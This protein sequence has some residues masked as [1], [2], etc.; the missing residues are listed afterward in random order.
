MK[1][2]VL[3][4]NFTIMNHSFRTKQ[5]HTLKIRSLIEVFVCYWLIIELN[6][7]AIFLI[8][9][10]FSCAC[11]TTFILAFTPKMT[12][13]ILQHYSLY[14]KLMYFSI[15]DRPFVTCWQFIPYHSHKV[16]TSIHIVSLRSNTFF[17]LYYLYPRVQLPK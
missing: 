9:Y 15:P 7:P 11:I 17:F 6:F 14:H 3:K 4:I 8:I 1:L 16:W 13:R 12:N 10:T 5:I 2:A